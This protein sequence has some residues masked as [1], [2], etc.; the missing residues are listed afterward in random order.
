[1]LAPTWSGES[2][3]AMEG[4]EM[5]RA[6]NGEPFIR[7]C[8]PEGKFVSWPNAIPR[9]ERRNNIEHSETRMGT[10]EMPPL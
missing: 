2:V 8:G 3:N 7:Y 9:V 1:L 10:S 5:E 6:N 4:V